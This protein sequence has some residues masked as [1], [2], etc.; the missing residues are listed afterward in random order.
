[1][2]L[3]IFAAQAQAWASKEVPGG[4]WV[5]EHDIL[6]NQSLLS[7]MAPTYVPHS[8]Q[9]SAV[10]ILSVSSTKP[11]TALRSSCLSEEDCGP[12]WAKRDVGSGLILDTSTHGLHITIS[13]ILW[14]GFKRNQTKPSIDGAVPQNVTV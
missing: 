10:R 2:H 9:S 4:E 3:R 12:T 11:T 1:M 13:S 5:Y 14:L 6:I 8:Y 7:G